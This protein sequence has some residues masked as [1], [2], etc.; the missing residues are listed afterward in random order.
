[1]ELTIQESQG[2]ARLT[3]QGDIDEAGA[4]LLKQRFQTFQPDQLKTVEL[5]FSKVSHIGSAGIGKLLMFY[6]AVALHGGMVRILNPNPDIR[7]LFQELNLHTLFDI[8]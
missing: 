1:M 4:A 5:D 6:K 3:I 7:A 2:M 8:R